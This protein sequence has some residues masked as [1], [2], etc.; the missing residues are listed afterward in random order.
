MATVI[1]VTNQKGGVGKTII[2]YQL[3]RALAAAG[4]RVL[5]VDNDPQGNFSE[6]CLPSA[7]DAVTAHVMKLYQGHTPLPQPVA[8]GL[9][10]IGSDIQLAPVA[11]QNF[12]VIFKLREGLDHYRD[13]YD[14]IVVDSVPSF[15][16]LHIAALACP[17]YCLIPAKPSRHA[18]SGLADQFG[19]IEKAKKRLNPGLKIVGI[20]LNL[21][22]TKNVIIERNFEEKLRQEYGDIVFTSMLFKRVAYEEATT[23]GEF[24]EDYDKKTAKNEFDLFYREFLTRIQEA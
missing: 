10:L 20:I 6:N 11:D 24:I 15:G 21:I 18:F 19:S 9:D 22:D 3:S 2:A 5:A 8:S 23:L 7:G 16:Q 13:S 4:N 1:T 17:D 12:E 14:Y